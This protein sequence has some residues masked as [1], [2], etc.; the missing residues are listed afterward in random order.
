MTTTI[1]PAKKTTVPKQAAPPG[2]AKQGA[3]VKIWAF[4]GALLLAFEAYVLIK[5]VTGP[6]FQ[7]VPP[8]PTPV[9]LG[10]KI[11]GTAIT[12]GGAVATVWF[13]WQWVVKPWRRS[14]TVTAEG[15]ML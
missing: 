15:L 3:A 11:A 9:P 4:F 14:R 5:W 10:F 2:A 8:G 12:I 1:E 13:F 6:N 7:N